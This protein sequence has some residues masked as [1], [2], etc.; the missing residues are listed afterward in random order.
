VI[1]IR[2][3]ITE[4]TV[5][6]WAK[7]AGLP[8]RRRGTRHKLTP[9]PKDMVIVAEVSNLDDD[10]LTLEEIGAKYGYT[11]AGIHRIYHKW[12]WWKPV[13][14]FGV[15]EVIRYRNR[16]YQVVEARVFDG[17]VRDLR[18]GQEETISWRS[19]PHIAVRLHPEVSHVNGSPATNT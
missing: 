3:R 2:Y 11:R 5:S 13:V 17:V 7:K 10:R 9:S 8:R 18:T 12:K 4:G 6:I 14:P 15:G 19:G 16:D 1:A